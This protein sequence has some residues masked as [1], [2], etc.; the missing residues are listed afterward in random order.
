MPA[1][2]AIQQMASRSWQ[3]RA[4]TTRTTSPFQQEN[5]NASEHQRQFERIATTWPSCSRGR[6]RPV[7][8]SSKSPCFSSGDKRAWRGSRLPSSCGPTAV[9]ALHPLPRDAGPRRRQQLRRRRAPLPCP[10]RSSAASSGTPGSATARDAG[11]VADRNAGLH[12]LSD[13]GQFQLDR[14][15]L[16]AT[17]L[18][19][20]TFENVSDIG[21][22]LGLSLDPPTGARVRSKQDAVHTSATVR[23]CVWFARYNYCD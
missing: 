1:V 16:P 2:V 13:H 6:R 21:T 11:N 19:T 23:C 9:R 4:K 5:S 12:R 17:P 14:E 22:C 8:R 20:S 3:S 7:W 18:I 15:T 10:L